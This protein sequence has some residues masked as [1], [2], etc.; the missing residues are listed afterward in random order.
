MLEE[1]AEVAKGLDLQRAP[2]IPIVSNLTGELLSPEQATD[3][4]YWVPHVREPVRFADCGRDPGK[5]R[6]HHLPRARPRP[7]AHR[8]GPGVPGRGRA[9]PA[10]VPTLR[11]GR[12]EAQAPDRRPRPGPRRRRQGRLGRFFK[13][14]GAKRVPLPTYP[15]Q[16]QRYWLD[17]TTGAGD[18]AARSGRP[19][20][21]TRCSAPRSKTPPA[22]G[23]DPDRPP[24][25][26]THPWL[27]DHAVAGT[28]LLPGT[29]FLELALRAAEEAGAA[30]R[31]GADPAGAADPPRA[32][33]GAAPGRRRAPR[34]GRG[35][36]EL[37]IHSRPEAGRGGEEPQWTCHAQGTLSA[38]QPPAARATRRLAPRGR[39]AARGRAPLRAPRR[40]R[41]RVRPR[42]PGPERRLAEARRSTPRSRWPRSR[43]GEAERFGIHPALLD[44]ALH[45][46]G[47]AGARGGEELRA[48]LRLERRQPRSATGATQLRVRLSPQGRGRPSPRRRR[49]RRRAGRSGRL[50]RSRGRSTAPAAG[51]RRPASA[52]LADRVA[53]GPRLGLDEGRA[54]RRPSTRARPPIGRPRTPSCGARPATARPTR[55]PRRIA[56]PCDGS[57]PGW[58]KSG[59]A[60]LAICSPEGAIATGEERG[61]RPRLP[62]LWGLVRSAQSEHPGRFALID[63]D[64]SEASAQALPAALAPAPRSPSSPCARASCWRRAGPVGE[65]RG[66]ATALAGARP[67]AHRPDHRRHRRPRRAGRPPPGRASTAPAT[68]SWSAA[69]GARAPRAPR[70]CARELEELG[71]EVEIAACDV[72]DRAQLEELLGSI[73]DEHPLGAVST[74]PASLDDGVLESLDARAARAVLAPQGRRRLAPARADRGTRPLAP[75]SSSPRPPASLGGAG[76]ANYAAA[77]AFLDALAAAAP[78]AQGCRPPRSPGGSGSASSGDGARRA[79]ARPTWRA[80]RARLGIA[81]LSDRAGPRP[82][83]RGARRSTEPLLVAGR[84]STPP[85]CARRPRPG[86]LPALL[87]GLVRCRRA[88]ASQAGAAR[89]PS[90]SPACPRQSARRVVLEL[91]RGRGRRGARPRLG[92]G[93]RARPGLQGARLRLAGRGRAAQPARR[94]TG[95]RLPADPGLRLPDRRRVSPTTCSPGRRLEHRR[96][97]R[98]RPRRRA[99]VRDALA[100]IPLVAA[101]RGRPARAAAGAG[102]ASDGT[103]RRAPARAGALERDRRRWTSTTWS[104]STLERQDVEPARGGVERMKTLRRADRREALRASLKETRAAARSSNRRLRRR[105]RRADRDRRHGL[106]LPRRRQLARG[107]LGAGRRRAATRSRRSPTDRGWDLERLYDPD[108]DQPGT[109]YAREGGFLDDAG[110]V[111]PRVLRHQPARG[112][113]DGPAAAAAAGS[114]LGGA[115]GRRHRPGLAA[116]QRRPASSPGVMYHDY[117]GGRA[118]S[119]RSSRATSAPARSAASSPAASPTRSA[120]RAR[121]SRST[122]PAPP[123]W[124]RC[125]WPRRRC[126]RASARWRWPA[127]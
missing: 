81:P 121:R 61:T 78:G 64:G 33:R 54:R 69:R 18:V 108:P 24:L 118:A 83:R 39:R 49:R 75:S 79:R 106:P 110:R 72:A 123:R 12:P 55:S 101:A 74:P 76:Q 82:L 120:S 34:R 62:P 116:R 37:A 23:A 96:R 47:L 28:V 48:A 70:S 66:A 20:P 1:F 63:T 73:P 103:G 113:G 15:F 97:R 41:P 125:T 13:G 40:A 53:D 21:S 100:A 19:T 127:G 4:A 52:A 85:R 59:E 35:R 65:R 8:D 2:Q 104:S 90:G 38:E 122:P 91:V 17:S 67:R 107:A 27:A 42:L 56:G 94:A 80:D 102:R 119:R 45:A 112:A 43:Q 31:R 86:P 26:A 68:C 87:R 44:A 10:F 124:W 29:A 51:R 88:P 25:L 22:E 11:Q 57:R 77:N 46:I 114:R 50:P 111:R 99:A 58:P 92:R 93:D 126:A 3:P 16:R 84:A 95:L 109:S 60:R 89:S 14:T 5:P 30:E 105:A 32:G 7:G 9:Q 98:E 117:G 36:R 115:G 6:H 71:A